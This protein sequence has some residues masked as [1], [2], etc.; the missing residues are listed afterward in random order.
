M[1]ALLGAFLLASLVPLFTTSWRSHLIGIGL[2]GPLLAAMAWSSGE[3]HASTS[4]ILSLVDLALL[5]GAL[6][7]SMLYWRLD[8]AQVPNGW[9]VAPVSLLSSALIGA[10]L[11]LSFRLAAAFGEGHPVPELHLATSVAAIL[12]GFYLL[13][14]QGSM[15]AQ[16]IGLL[17]IENGIALFEL[18]APHRPPLLVQLGLLA[19]FLFT[20]LYLGAFANPQAPAAPA[21]D[22]PSL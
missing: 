3:A 12:L 14:S 20:V 22:G 21:E 11:L 10:L 2:Q 1:S 4:M 15:F 9:K 5:R 17:R 18:M 16:M 19:L 7:P 8:P 13:A 6:A